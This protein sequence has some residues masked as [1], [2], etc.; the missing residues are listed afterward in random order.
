MAGADCRD[1][2]C[3]TIVAPRVVVVVVV[4]GRESGASG[5]AS[6]GALFLG[7]GRGFVGSTGAARCLLLSFPHTLALW[8]PSHA[9]Q[10]DAESIAPLGRQVVPQVRATNALHS[11]KLVNDHVLADHLFG[12]KGGPAVVLALLTERR[13]GPADRRPEER[14]TANRVVERGH[15]SRVQL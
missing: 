3:R 8:G 12:A 11:P 7:C 2:R 13:K 1:L 5:A 15:V 14:Q 4:V 6:I 9:H 10:V